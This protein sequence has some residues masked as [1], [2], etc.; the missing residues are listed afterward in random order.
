MIYYKNFEVELKHIIEFELF[1]T[2]KHSCLY[3]LLGYL[4]KYNNSGVSLFQKFAI[5]ILVPIFK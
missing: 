4:G 2:F 5:C 1:Y 3:A